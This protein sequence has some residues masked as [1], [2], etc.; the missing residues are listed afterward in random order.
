MIYFRG[1]ITH[2]DGFWAEMVRTLEDSALTSMTVV[3]LD[4][5]GIVGLS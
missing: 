4:L 3:R 2:F 1:K 5:G